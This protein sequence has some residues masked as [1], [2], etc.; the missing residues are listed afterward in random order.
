MAGVSGLEARRFGKGT[1]LFFVKEVNT[2]L[3]GAWVLFIIAGILR[4]M[5]ETLCKK[6]HSASRWQWLHRC[7]MPGFIPII[8]AA[9]L[10]HYAQASGRLHWELVKPMYSEPVLY[11]QHKLLF[12]Q[13]L[14]RFS[15]LIESKDKIWMEWTSRKKWLVADSVTRFFRIYRSPTCL[16]FSQI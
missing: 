12:K 5:A 1:L 4:Q 9:L 2:D 3:A 6:F 16:P 7:R 8:N 13:Q 15:A 11:T 14:W 10:G